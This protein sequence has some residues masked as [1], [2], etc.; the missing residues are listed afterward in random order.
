MQDDSEET[1]GKEKQE[2]DHAYIPTKTDIARSVTSEFII[3]SCASKF[4][5]PASLGL[6]VVSRGRRRR[7]RPPHNPPSFHLYDLTG[8]SSAAAPSKRRTL[9]AAVM[10]SPACIKCNSRKRKC[11][12]QHPA[13]S[14]FVLFGVLWLSRAMNVKLTSCRRGIDCV[15][16]GTTGQ[17]PRRSRSKV[18]STPPA[19]AAASSNVGDSSPVVTGLSACHATPNFPAVFYLDHDVFQNCRVEIPESSVTIPRDVL[20]SIGQLPDRINTAQEYFETAHTLI[21]IILKKRFFEKA[22][23]YVEVRADYALL[24]LCIDLIKWN[25]DGNNPRTPAYHTAKHF[26]LDLEI[27]GLKTIQ[28]LQAGLLIAVY[29]MGH[30][31]FPSASV[32]IE[33]CVR[34]GYDLGIDW[35][36]SRIARKPFAWV[37]P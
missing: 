33:A 9:H 26:Y 12:K 6:G 15:Y 28:V 11:D 34:Y 21:P 22:L 8:N 27:A 30:A 23:S 2:E 32:S 19:V 20:N 5:I 1:E 17:R 36:P 18:H 10:S 3:M 16:P 31:I 13:S 14:M 35:N 4:E 25:P 24:I 29:E 7:R 37:D